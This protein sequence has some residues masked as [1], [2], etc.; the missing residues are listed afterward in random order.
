M[1][2]LFNNYW[3][4]ILIF[5]TIKYITLYNIIY[6]IYTQCLHLAY[7]QKKNIIVYL[8]FSVYYDLTKD[9]FRFIDLL[10]CIFK[11]KYFKNL[12]F[13]PVIKRK[14]FNYRKLKLP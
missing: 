12:M 5:N 6:I 2:Y 4:L 7:I 11:S 9:V 10:Y 13:S 14:N 1:K 3:Y 8:L